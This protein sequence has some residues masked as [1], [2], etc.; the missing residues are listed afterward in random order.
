MPEPHADEQTIVRVE[1]VRQEKSLIDRITS[2]VPLSISVVAI[3]LSIWSAYAT[4]VHN[5]VTV[6]PFATVTRALAGPESERA[7]FSISNDGFGVAT[8]RNLVVYFDG[9]PIENWEPVMQ[10]VRNLQVPAV[11]SRWRLLPSVAAIRPG[12]PTYLYTVESKQL[13]DETKDRLNDL[14]TKRIDLFVEVCSA[15]EECQLICS[16][17][18]PGTCD[19]ARKAAEAASR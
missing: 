6:R 16:S 12:E 9:K 8:V 7:G 14:I 13:L 1:L 15:Y 17:T 4:R 11:T 5:R 10:V 2:L 18:I 19:E 3:G